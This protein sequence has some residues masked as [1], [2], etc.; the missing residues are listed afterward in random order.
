VK[1]DGKNDESQADV[2]LAVSD[3]AVCFIEQAG[4]PSQLH[5][6]TDVACFAF[7]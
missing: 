5:Y 6:M 4:A 1:E 7:H 3:T 2:I